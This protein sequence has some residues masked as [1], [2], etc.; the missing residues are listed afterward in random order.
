MADM[1]GMTNMGGGHHHGGGASGGG[2]MIMYFHGYI[3][4]D[5][6][7]FS[8]W[9]PKGPGATVGVCIGLF[10][11]AVLDRYLHALRAACN[12]AWRRGRVGWVLPVS[13]GEMG[14]APRYEE[15][16]HADAH[17]EEK[18]KAAHHGESTAVDE[19]GGS[20]ANRRREGTPDIE[21][22]RDRTPTPLATTSHAHPHAHAAAEAIAHLPATVRR[23]LDPGRVGRW[24]RPFR[25]G[26]DGPRGLLHALQQALHWLL[27]LV[28][29]TFQIYWII[30]IVV[31]A[32]VGEAMFG[33]FGAHR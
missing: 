6:L 3:G 10:L 12:E 26:V 13:R 7:W 29:M 27:M 18:G 16:E 2:T 11:L 25:W 23:T 30:A 20:A 28:V 33:R 4:Q 14:P 15:H 24:S 32:G 19:K 22:Q 9:V 21:A 17:L 1:S 31:G 8:T 5:T